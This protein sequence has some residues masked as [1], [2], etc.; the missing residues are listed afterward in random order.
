MEGIAAVVRNSVRLED[1]YDAMDRVLDVTEPD[2]SV[3]RTR[4]TN[5]EALTRD[6]A[7]KWRKTVTDAAGRLA[8][9]IEDPTGSIDGFSNPGGLS[10]STGYEYDGRGLLTKVTQGTQPPRDLG[11]S[12]LGLLETAANPE[13][14][15]P[16]TYEAGNLV[17]RVDAR[18]TSTLRYDVIGRIRTKSYF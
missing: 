18:A 8:T 11:Y 9:V 12:G 10:F 15:T 17:R 5:R 16:T 14:L 7:R 2:G 1:K 6:P 13:S 4:Y 3:T